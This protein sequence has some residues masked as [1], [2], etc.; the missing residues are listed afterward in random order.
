MIVMH[1]AKP[2]KLQ[3]QALLIADKV[4]VR[5]D[6]QSTRIIVVPVRV[7]YQ[8]VLYLGLVRILCHLASF[9]FTQISMLAEHNEELMKIKHAG[10]WSMLATLCIC[11]Y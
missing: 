11:E 1:H 7:L 5:K 3:C 10:P 2:N 9:D 8:H 4:H 6:R